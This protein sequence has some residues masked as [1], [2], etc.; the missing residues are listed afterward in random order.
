MRLSDGPIAGYVA[1]VVP[2]EEGSF[3]ICAL[4]LPAIP[5]LELISQ[6]LNKELLRLRRHERRANWETLLRRRGEVLYR[7]CA[8]FCWELE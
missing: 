5:P 2:L 7:L 4:A 3:T 6:R 1:R 8:S